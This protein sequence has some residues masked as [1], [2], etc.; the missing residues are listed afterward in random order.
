MYQGAR[1][2]YCR[3]PA[4]K[5]VELIYDLGARHLLFLDPGLTFPGKI[6][7]SD[8]DGIPHPLH[9]T[10][11][12][13]GATTFRKHEVI[14]TPFHV[15]SG[16]A[17]EAQPA[18]LGQRVDAFADLHPQ[19]IQDGGRFRAWAGGRLQTGEHATAAQRLKSRE[20]AAGFDLTSH[21]LVVRY[22]ESDD[23]VNWRAP[24]L[25]V[26]EIEDRRTNIVFGTLQVPERGFSGMKVFV[27]PSASPAGRYKGLFGGR[28]PVSDLVRYC[29]EAGEP[30]DPMSLLVQLSR[31]P[32]DQV[33]AGGHYE[34]IV[35]GVMP[36]ELDTLPDSPAMVFFGA[37]SPDGLHWTPTPNP[38]L[39]FMAEEVTPCWD[40][41]HS[42]YVAYARYWQRAQ[43]RSIGLT[44]TTDFHRWPLPRPILFPSYSEDL[45]VDYY[46][47]CHSL[48]PGTSDVHLFFV[49]RYRRGQDDCLDLH[50][51]V[52]LDGEAFDFVPGDPVV[53]GD[54]TGWDPDAESPSACV[55]P[56]NDLVQ[57]DADHVGII[58]RRD[59]FP[60]KWPRTTQWRHIVQ[61]AL[62]ENE[63]LV[64]LRAA[65]RGELTTCGF[66]LRA[67]TIYLNVTTEPAGSLLVRVLDDRG[68]PVDGF[69]FEEARPINGDHRR[70]PLRWTTGPLP[71][72]LIDRK[73]YLELKMYQTRL[74][75]IW[76]AE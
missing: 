25:D 52:S 62:W 63:R 58:V 2:V 29:R 56:T 5:E 15:P 21:S 54:A 16:V 30:F 13:F 47:N 34:L 65:E 46:T 66:M 57:F 55:F 49:S 18:T 3:Y 9:A 72:R 22:L 36:E 11:E 43:R 75:S 45:N 37:E 14:G 40:A 60:H 12:Y 35:G 28:L 10:A 27:D 39:T 23:G 24:D 26:V 48:Y 74:Y 33:E 8:A 64:A 61:W 71:S 68:E 31:M 6:I 38:V 59:N 53:A 44:S 4:T 19:I 70:V 76:A 7:W 50:L 67:P 17:F 73:I 42:R 51:A 1:N 69:G 32:R 41:E 20:E